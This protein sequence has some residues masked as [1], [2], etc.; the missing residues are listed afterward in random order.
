[1]ARFGP[2]ICDGR[3]HASLHSKMAHTAWKLAIASVRAESKDPAGE[4]SARRAWADCR[5]QYE[6]LVKG[7]LVCEMGIRTC[8]RLVDAVFEE[9][10]VQRVQR[11]QQEAAG[12]H[13]LNEEAL[14]E[15][16]QLAQE[17]WSL[18]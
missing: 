13:A 16:I 10:Q 6:G 5:T 7:C 18:E 17:G 8:F 1:M 14:T 2:D 11:V 12:R 4:S 3:V 15:V 9:R